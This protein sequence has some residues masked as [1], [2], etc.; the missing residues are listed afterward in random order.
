[1]RQPYLTPTEAKDL[2]G[3]DDKSL[4][5]L[6]STG[7]LTPVRISGRLFFRTDEIERLEDLISSSSSISPVGLLA[8]FNSR[9]AKLEQAVSIL[10]NIVRPSVADVLEGLDQDQLADIL[11]DAVKDTGRPLSAPAIE[12]WL[13]IIAGL[14]SRHLD[15][16]EKKIRRGDAWEVFAALLKHIDTQPARKD[17]QG[18]HSLL[19]QARDNLRDL[20]ILRT[21]ELLDGLFIAHPRRVLVGILRDMGVR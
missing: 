19:R 1:M 21:G 8:N 10:A 14:S 7:L 20:V 2:L 18:Y 3:T 13:M 5:L 15:W 12:K 6:V 4:D 16:M 17:V 11:A 9:L